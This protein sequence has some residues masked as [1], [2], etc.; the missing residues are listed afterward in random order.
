MLSDEDIRS[1]N[2]DGAIEK[3]YGLGTGLSL[4]VI[5]D[6]W[7]VKS[8]GI[9]PLLEETRRCP[10]EIMYFPDERTLA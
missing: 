5:S 1:R 8:G 2:L 10:A 7:V 6:N 3:L 4:R 9:F